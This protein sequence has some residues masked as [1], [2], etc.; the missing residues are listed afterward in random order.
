MIDGG[1]LKI[2]PMKMKATIKWSIP[3]NVT[4]IRSFV[5]AT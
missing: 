3:T 5:G 1:E 4:D 2:D